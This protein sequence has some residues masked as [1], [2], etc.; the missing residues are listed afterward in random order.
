MGTAQEAPRQAGAR[1]PASCAGPHGS[2]ELQAEREEAGAQERAARAKREAAAAELQAA[3][4][5][6]VRAEAEAHEQRAADVDP[7]SDGDDR[8]EEGARTR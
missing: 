5:E 8:E 3:R 2:H 7:D 6:N 1:R 4:A